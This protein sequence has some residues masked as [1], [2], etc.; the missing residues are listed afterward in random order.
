MQNALPWK[1]WLLTPCFS[2]VA[3]L[4]VINQGG[5]KPGKPG[6][7][8]D[9][10][11]HGKLRIL[12]EFCA[13]SGKNCNEAF[14]VCHSNIWLES[15]GDLLYCWSWCGMTLDEGH[16]HLAPGTGTG[17]CFRTISFFLSLFLCQQHYEKTAGP[18]CMKFSCKVWSDHRTTW[19]HF[20]SI[21]VNGSAGQRSICLLSQG[22]SSEETS[23]LHLLGVSRGRGLL[24]L[25]PQLATFTLCC[26]NLWKSKFMALEK[27]AKLFLL[28]C[29][30]PVNAYTLINWLL[31]SAVSLYES[32][33]QVNSCKWL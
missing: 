29:G 18:I 10:C 9:F 24:C 16:Y 22:H 4:L 27:P 2:V 32:C 21:R 20:G 14:L 1:K 28:L 19:L 30:H 3:E 17:Y 31:Q 5:H 25:A 8:R 6:I 15:G 23:Q 11:E 26:N 12:R 7:L 33:F 13:T